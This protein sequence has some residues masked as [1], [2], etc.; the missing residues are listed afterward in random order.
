MRRF[1]PI[2]AAG[3][4]CA[5]APAAGHAA[6][7]RST[8][9][10]APS[11]WVTFEASAANAVQQ[12]F[13]AQGLSAPAI[14]DTRDGIAVSQVRE[15]QLEVLSAVMHERFRRCPG[16][17][18]HTSRAEALRAIALD[19]A[20]PVTEL[21]DFY[22]IDNPDAVNAILPNLVAANIEQTIVT[23]S[24][25]PTRR[26]EQLGGRQAARWVHDRWS[27]L[28]L[29]IPGARVEYFMAATTPMPS[30]IMTIPGATR[31]DQVVVMGAHLDSTSSGALAPGA[32]DDAS[33]VA[34]LTEVVRAAMAAG[35]RP[36]RTL[37]IMAY[38]GEE[39][40][41]LGSRAIATAYRA[42][43]VNV[44]GVLQLDMTNFKGSAHA[45]IAIVS[46]VTRTNFEQNQFLKTLINVYVGVPWIETTCGYGCSDHQS[47]TEKGYR[48]SF[49]FESQF[50]FHNA[51]IH[52]PNDTLTTSG[53]NAEHSLKFAKLAA[54]YMAEMAKGRILSP[55]G[56]P[57]LALPA[58]HG[59]E[60]PRN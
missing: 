23:L 21:T 15:D 17:V 20:P 53:G 6:R 25:I 26:H 57:V 33:G 12:A 47:W 44:I 3:A 58:G 22:V 40:G 7:A 45:D 8:A 5:A 29:G 19:A 11:V 30:V 49:P 18:S 37:K 46:D 52:T 28:P 50:G 9:G 55:P 10:I 51:A 48:A 56:L 27:A 1:L 38:A 31:P 35:Y 32:D 2:L 16:F 34:T 36:D 43:N 59:D 60:A 13:A 24:S 39:V 4:I 54:A 42:A 41:L 14:L